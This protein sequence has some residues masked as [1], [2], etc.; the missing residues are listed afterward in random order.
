MKVNANFRK[1]WQA[2]LGRRVPEPDEAEWEPFVVWLQAERP[3]VYEELILAVEHQGYTDPYVGAAR[4]AESR[5]RLR[6]GLD[7]LFRERDEA[8][9]Q[10]VASKPKLYAWLWGG[11]LAGMFGVAGMVALSDHPKPKLT[12]VAE[13]TLPAPVV[14]SPIPKPSPLS[15]KSAPKPAPPPQPKPKVTVN[16]GTSPRSDWN[17]VPPAK[18]IPYQPQAVQVRQPAPLPIPRLEGAKSQPSDPPAFTPP[19]PPEPASSPEQAE[20]AGPPQPAPPERPG[21]GF[22][23]YALDGGSASPPADG[24][25]LPPD[26]SAKADAAVPD[27]SLLGQGGDGGAV[28]VGSFYTAQLASGIL[29]TEDGGMRT[30]LRS[31]G[32][33]WIGRA[34]LGASKRVEIKLEEVIVG[35]KRLPVSAEVYTGSAQPEA[36]GIGPNF[37]DETPAFVA[38]AV[39]GALRGVSQYVEGLGNASQTTV[40][41]GVVISQNATPGLLESVTGS[42]ASLLAAPK[43][44]TARVRVAEVPVGTKVWVLVLGDGPER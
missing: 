26:P 42:L 8:T 33:V 2:E 39:A 34:A 36:P 21:Q 3:E 15:D 41:N 1:K 28:Q 13:A 10:M 40:S 7:R 20:A 29:L 24:Q 35:G 19:P 16:K 25:N 5:S 44:A 37:R 32:A 31:T 38:D 43:N 17:Y 27:F 11:M 30:V 23:L 12:P 6:R 18:P 9:G 22:V 4:A 14:P